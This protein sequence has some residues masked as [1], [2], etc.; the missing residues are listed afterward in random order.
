MELARHFGPTG[1]VSPYV[2]GYGA[3]KDVWDYE[4]WLYGAD[5]CYYYFMQAVLREVREGVAKEQAANVE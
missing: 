2:H 1:S 4:L 3:R 5:I